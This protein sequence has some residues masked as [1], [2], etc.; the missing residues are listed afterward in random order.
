MVFL[1][2]PLLRFGFEVRIL[3]LTDLHLSVN[4]EAIIHGVKPWET[5]LTVWRDIQTRFQLNELDVLV[6]SGDVSDDG[7]LLSYIELASTLS[8]FSGKL[9][10]IPGNHDKFDPMQRVFIEYGFPAQRLIIQD[11]WAVVGLNSQEPNEVA[12]YLSAHELTWLAD[13]LERH[14]NKQ[15][16]IFLHHHVL[17]INSVWLDNIR[18]KNADALLSLVDHYSNVRAIVNGHVHQAYTW[19]RESIHYYATPATCW[20]FKPKACSFALHDLP[21]GYRVLQCDTVINS[22]VY[23]VN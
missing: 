23:Y 10:Y 19:Q 17:K 15:F 16:V 18:L 9:L 2:W 13:C 3:Q 8:D 1:L 20:Q 14:I 12:G 21:P 11:D 22:D 4:K 6:L 5:W 7:S